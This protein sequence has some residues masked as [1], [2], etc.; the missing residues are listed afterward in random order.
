MKKLVYYGLLLLLFFSP[1]HVSAQKESGYSATHL[2]FDNNLLKWDEVN[3]LLPKFSKFTVIDFET[4]LSFK[5]QRR[6]GRDHTDVQPLTQKDTKIMKSIY[7]GKW[8][9]KRR[10]ILVQFDDYLIPAS[11]HGMPHGAGA[12]QNSF[13]G[14]FC[15]HFYGSSTH[16][17]DQMDFSH[18][19]MILKSAGQLDDYVFNASSNDFVKIFV[20]GMNQQ[21]EF[22][23]DLVL[24]KNWRRDKEFLTKLNDIQTIKIKQ[25]ELL[26]ES[27]FV[28]EAQ[29]EIVMYSKKNGKMKGNLHVSMVRSYPIDSWEVVAS[30]I[31][32]D[33]E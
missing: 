12:L 14:H 24:S 27:P 3:S 13:P 8:S 1:V 30:E 15:I 26:T 21:D 2:S 31:I 28:S 11:M 9:W 6:A 32:F 17:T 10:A 19:L 7:G 25:L 20:E 18:S 29:V 22:I 4:G 16:R 33:V 5:V 23:L